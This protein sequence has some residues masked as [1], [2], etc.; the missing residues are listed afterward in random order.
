MTVLATK[1]DLGALELRITKQLSDTR[2]DIIKWVAGMLIA[3]A[4][5]IAALVKLLCLMVSSANWLTLFN[6]AINYFLCRQRLHVTG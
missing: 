5:I 2:A 1:S 4:A 3:Q 6:L